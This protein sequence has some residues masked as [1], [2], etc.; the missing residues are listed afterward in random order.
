MKVQDSPQFPVKDKTKF[1]H[2]YNFVYF[3]E[4]SGA[5]PLAFESSFSINHHISNLVSDIAAFC[6]DIKQ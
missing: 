2:Q 6:L 3:S 1:K 5:R 4:C